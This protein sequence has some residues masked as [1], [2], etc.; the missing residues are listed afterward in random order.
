MSFKNLL[1]LISV[2]LFT[3]Y[4]ATLAADSKIILFTAT[5]DAIAGA[6]DVGITVDQDLDATSFIYM[7]QGKETLVPLNDLAK[8]VVLYQMSGKNVAVLSSPNFNR[9]QGGLLKLTYLN[10][11]LQ[12]T[13]KN[14]SFSLGRQGQNWNSTI[15]DANGVAIPF[16]QMFLYGKKVFGQTVGIDRI[17]V[18]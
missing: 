12:N 15:T 7:D 14:F 18:K 3:S 8:G 4:S 11:G 17:T 9:T 10:N 13:Y 16:T 6:L 2:G 5:S 1:F